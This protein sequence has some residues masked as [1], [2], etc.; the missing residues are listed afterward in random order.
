MSKKKPTFKSTPKAA[1]RLKLRIFRDDLVTR[2]EIAYLLEIKPCAL[3]KI[4]KKYAETEYPFP[5][6]IVVNVPPIR[7]SFQMVKKWLRNPLPQLDLVVKRE[8]A[9][10]EKE[11]KKLKKQQRRRIKPGDTWRGEKPQEYRWSLW[12]SCEK[13]YYYST[14][15]KQV[16]Y[17]EMKIYDCEGWWKAG[18]KTW[19]GGGMLSY[20]YTHI[21]PSIMFCG[22]V[23]GVGSRVGI[24]LK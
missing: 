12:H 10:Q 5:A 15:G 21:H 24:I 13:A 16:E 18:E 20:I 8:A 6:P 19:G 14:N 17:K 9:M 2:D 22:W 4:I 11:L 7:Y 23:L 1:K 3:L